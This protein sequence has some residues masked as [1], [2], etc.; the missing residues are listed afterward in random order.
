[1]RKLKEELEVTPPDPL[2]L[3]EAK[4]WEA[5]LHKQVEE[6]LAA[7]EASKMV[8]SSAASVGSSVNENDPE[9]NK[10][11]SNG[12]SSGFTYGQRRKHFEVKI[13]KIEAELKAFEAEKLSIDRRRLEHTHAMR[14][15][16]ERLL[17]LSIERD[18]LKHF[19]GQMITSDVLTGADIQYQT[20]DYVHRV[21]RAY[22]IV[23]QDI[24]NLKFAVITGENRK[25]QLKEILLR[26]EDERKN[27]LAKFLEFEKKSQKTIQLIKR[28]NISS[29]NNSQ[30]SSEAM[31]DHE[32]QRLMRNHFDLFVEYVEERKMSRIRIVDLFQDMMSR[33]K[34]QGFDK[35]KLYYKRLLQAESAN[36]SL[37][38]SQ[39]VVVQ[40]PGMKKKSKNT[41]KPVN[42]SVLKS[43]EIDKP[44]SVG[45]TMLEM[46]YEKRLEFQD[47]LREMVNS[48]SIVHQKLELARL[49]KDSRKQLTSLRAFRSME[50]GIDHKKL[51]IQ[52]MKLM[53]EADG[54][55]KEGRFELALSLYDAQILLIRSR[56]SFDIKLLS[57]C[58]GRLGRMFLH[59]GKN[60]R[61]IVEFD[62]QLSLAR[63]IRDKAE[64]SDAFSGLGEGYLQVFDYENAVRYLTIAQAQLHA[65]NRTVKYKHTLL[66]L[67]SCYEKVDKPDKVQAYQQKI[68]LVDEGMTLKIRKMHEQL[69][70]MKSRL[71][72]TA[73]EIELIIKVERTT[74]RALELKD[75]IKTGDERLKELEAEMKLQVQSINAVGKILDAIQKEMEQALATDE[76][77]IWSELVHDQ[78]QI[79]EVEELKVR[80]KARTVIELKRRQDEEILQ[81]QIAVRISNVENSVLEADQQLAVEEGNL[82]K[83]SHTTKPFRCVGLCTTNV[84]GNEV[85]G[86]ATGGQEEFSASE[87][88][89][90]HLIDYHN[91]ELK[92]I[93]SGGKE[94]TGHVGAVTCLL[95]DGS[96]LFSGS[97]D[98]RILCWDIETLSLT[99]ILTGHEGSIVALASESNILASTASDNT[100]RLWSK[101]N[102]DQL[103]VVFGH[104]KSVLSLEIGANW[105]LTGSADHEARLWKIIYKNKGDID[106]L[107]SDRLLLEEEAKKA[108]KKKKNN[109]LRNL[110]VECTS[111]LQ[112]HNCAVT[113]VKYGAVEVVTA[114]QQGRIFVWW[115]KTGEVIRQCQAHTGPV[116]CLQFDSVHIVSCGVDGIVCIVD[117]ATGEVMIIINFS[118]LKSYLMVNLMN[119]RFYRS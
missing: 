5:V 50:E 28:L 67:K 103:R 9:I 27:K 49:S 90:I 64:E 40:S 37:E 74:I 30:A 75:I 119:D 105:M 66:L 48:T 91:G 34:R 15:K 24:A 41:N 20:A 35:W 59:L 98:E 19:H 81:K 32:R 88:I 108:P 102:G 46:A 87:G 89:H 99:R 73:A 112:G 29:A 68:E 53:Y 13:K 77:E 100:I 117:I 106:S 82:M 95:L 76:L 45:G 25:H 23:I 60:A 18:R 26:K 57:I 55:V 111:R 56:P 52:G 33:L 116:K 8:K 16:E 97:T 65:L 62:R 36:E 84:A 58:H 113:C 63:E 17:T 83:H 1:M 94:A 110:A 4:E 115:M 43:V 79:V 92:H 72:H 42:R 51:Y 101:S 11:L 39:A 22:E 21:E 38:N 93:F 118:L 31:D 70:D 14:K 114:D 54:Y 3:E 6:Q 2:E 85:T 86:T 78:P 69:D 96:M 71:V 7:Q 12:D 44:I 80:L 47:S 104:S 10:L 109:K 61:A 107:N